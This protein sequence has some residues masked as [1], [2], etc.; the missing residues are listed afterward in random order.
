[1]AEGGGRDRPI[2]I[3]RTRTGPLFRN[4][5]DGAR[6]VGVAGSTID[7]FVQ[8]IKK[9]RPLRD[10]TICDRFS[11]LNA[12]FRVQ[13]PS[14]SSADRLQF[15]ITVES[16]SAVT[17]KHARLRR[18]RRRIQIGERRYLLFACATAYRTYSS[19]CTDGPFRANYARAIFVQD[20][21]TDGYGRV[22]CNRETRRR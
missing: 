2:R 13:P 1:M 9:K 17:T 3:G 7:F 18:Y 10:D 16:P 15:V 11:P 19:T 6:R 4:R 8:E 21:R 14:S 20:I 5:R 12:S 22:I